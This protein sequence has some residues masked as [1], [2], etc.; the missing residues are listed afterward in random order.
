MKKR[1]VVGFK[2]RAAPL[3]GFLQPTAIAWL[4]MDRLGAPTWA[5][6]VMWTLAAIISIGFAVS[7]FTQ[8][9]REPLWSAEPPDTF[10]A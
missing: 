1:Y 7:H 10:D 4:L 8:T 3:F 5:Y 9:E 6:G 2:H